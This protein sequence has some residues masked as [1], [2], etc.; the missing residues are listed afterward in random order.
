MSLVFVAS[1]S[2]KKEHRNDW[3]VYDKPDYDYCFSYPARWEPLELPDGRLTHFVTENA[4]K[5]HF[6]IGPKS[7]RN[8]ADLDEAFEWYIN[9][10]DDTGQTRLEKERVK[11]VKGDNCSI[12][13]IPTVSITDK[14][15]S[16]VLID[17][18][19]DIY[20]A[21]VSFEFAEK[22]VWEILKSITKNRHS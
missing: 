11:R 13:E 19:G 10:S 4:D 16:I 12:I 14:Q 5:V 9:Q 6:A 22:T 17:L 21:V 18:E 15:E 1:I 7:R 3:I 2:C 20:F 8:W